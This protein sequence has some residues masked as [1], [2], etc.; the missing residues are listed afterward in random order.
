MLKRAVTR[1]L[2]GFRFEAESPPLAEWLPRMDVACF[3]G[4]AA[5][6]PIDTPVAVE[7]AAQFEAVFGADAPLAWD[8]R[9]GAQVRAHLAPAVRAFFANGGRRCWIVRVAGTAGTG[10][11]GQD[12][13]LNRARENYFPVPG[14]AQARLNAEGKIEGLAPA[15]ARARSEGSWSDALEVS[16]ALLSRPAQ[17]KSFSPADLSL[18][19]AEDAPD[20]LSPGDLLR[21]TFDDGSILFLFIARVEAAPVTLAGARRTVR[22][23]GEHPVW[24]Q[25]ALPAPLRYGKTAVALTIYTSQADATP[26][27]GFDARAAA[28]AFANTYS[29]TLS[30]AGVGTGSKD[31]SQVTLEV[32]LPLEDAPAPGS[33]VV[34]EGVGWRG[35]VTVEGLG[36]ASRREG[37]ENVTV[38]LAGRALWFPE[39]APALPAGVPPAGERISF[40]LR[41]R[42]GN[43]YALGISDLAFGARHERFW[44]RL[45]TD[46]EVIRSDENAPVTRPVEDLW[47]QLGEQRFP[48]AAPEAA[49]EAGALFFPLSMSPLADEF[50]GA[51][52]LPGTAL[53]RDGL[54][55]F[56]AALFLDAALASATAN[57][58]LPR[59]DFIRYL[60]DKPRPLRGIHA[61]LA[62]EEVTIIA[63][64][65]A[66]QRGW[67]EA[68]DEQPRR[69]DPSRPFPRPDWWHFLDCRAHAQVPLARRPQLG[70]FL[71][72]GVGVVE[73][74][75]LQTS[76]TLSETGTYTLRWRPQLR[77]VTFDARPRFILEE[78]ASA[79]FGGAVRVYE[80]AATTFTLDGR[81]PGDYYYRVRVELETEPDGKVE[82]SDWSNGVAVRV[83]ARSRWLQNDEKAYDPADL[84]GVQRALLRLAAARADLFAVLSLPEHFR[85]DKSLEHAAAL[86]LTLTRGARATAGVPALND[87]ELGA[88]SYG[89][90]YHP[91]LTGRDAANVEKFGSAPPDGAACGVLARRALARGAWIAPANELFAGVLALT[92]SVSR[93][94]WLD[95]QLAQINLIRQEPRGV[96]AMNAD[97]LCAE[98]DLR[99][100]SV[101]RLL[102]LLR[103]LCLRH[104]ATY[105]F[106]PNGAALRRLVER[107][108]ESVLDSLFARGAF[109]GATASASYRVVATEALNTPQSIEEGRFIV[110]LRVAPSRPLTFM[111][112]RLVQ[113]GERGFV[114]EVRANG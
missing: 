56:D 55:E 15:F 22:V 103:R 57:D 96:V 112:L 87:G 72:C 75:L 26:P 73:R 8:T 65:D 7:S 1:R 35:L 2:P 54:A 47:Q 21:L 86:R 3:V 106:E 95:L 39:D 53:E 98:E 24:T 49:G 61:A 48:L 100:I 32:E 19:L 36:I 111:T 59:A 62:V 78:S 93:E 37:S 9:R 104:G 46:A 108:F 30:S 31:A 23:R 80:G 99:E 77:H 68:D 41:V 13:R 70:H 113:T 20:D 79:D 101:R 88:L 82:T 81:A 11:A 29:A 71:N 66:V 83:R 105:V 44:G 16:A 64:P 114:T 18:E 97:T 10:G 4:F 5:S 67:R 76:A 14:V 110:E 90:L 45:P 38:R 50:L 60:S 40:E 94:R 58:L 74:P 42:K 43:E 91:W 92:P 6:G 89:A 63:A 51:V 28:E 17:V 34:V 69:P 85:E 102:I 109:A 27:A 33:T 12:N 84:L 25:A 107:G 52:R